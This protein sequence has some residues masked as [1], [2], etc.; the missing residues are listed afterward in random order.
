MVNPQLNLGLQGSQTKKSFISAFI[1]GMH[2]KLAQLIELEVQ[3]GNCASFL[4]SKRGPKISSLFFM[5][6]SVPFAQASVEQA[7]VIK[8]CLNRLHSLSAKDKQC[9]VKCLFFKQC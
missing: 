7:S 9:K 6:D 3:N 4:T 2:G 1:R 5:D 8:T